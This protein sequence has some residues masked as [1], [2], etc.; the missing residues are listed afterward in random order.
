MDNQ[1]HLNKKKL[2]MEQLHVVQERMGSYN[3]GGNTIHSDLRLIS[4]QAGFHTLAFYNN[5]FTKFVYIILI[6]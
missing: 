5:E 6:S 3:V 4:T 1:E 2:T